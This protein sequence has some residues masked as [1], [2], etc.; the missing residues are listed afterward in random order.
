MTFFNPLN[1]Q[2]FFEAR[3]SHVIGRILMRTRTIRELSVAVGRSHF[4]DGTGTVSLPST[5]SGFEFNSRLRFP[6]LFRVLA[7]SGPGSN[8]V[9]ALKQGTAGLGINLSGPKAGRGGGAVVQVPLKI[10]VD[11]SFRLA[12]MSKGQGP[13]FGCRVLQAEYKCAPCPTLINI[14]FDSRDCFVQQKLTMQTG[15]TTIVMPTWC[16]IYDKKSDQA[17]FSCGISTPLIDSLPIPCDFAFPFGRK[18]SFLLIA[19]KVT[20]RER[21]RERERREMEE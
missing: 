14:R 8:L 9:R 21:E 6:D 19:T 18:R 3:I 12:V 13:N 16:K 20:E 11:L 15:S 17:S 4:A 7:A 1:L 2:R 10:T 5:V